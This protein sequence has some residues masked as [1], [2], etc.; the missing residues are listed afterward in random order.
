MQDARL[1]RR[2]SP[3]FNGVRLGDRRLELRVLKTVE[4]LARQPSA[5]ILAAARSTAEAEAMYRLLRNPR[6]SMPPILEPH[7]RLT[8]ERCAAVAKVLVIHDTSEFEYSGE[9]REG[10]GRLRTQSSQGFLFHGSL[11]VEAGT[12]Q[13]LG[14]VAIKTWVRGETPTSTITGRNGARKKSG[15][16]YARTEGKESDRWGQQIEASKKRL[17]HHNIVHVADREADIYSLLALLRE[18]GDGFVI[19]LA[20]DKKA[21]ESDDAERESLIEIA[22]RARASLQIDI[23]IAARTRSKM[24]RKAKTFTSRDARIA[25]VEMAAASAEIFG[26]RYA[27][28]PAPLPINVVH[29]RELDAPADQE[30]VEWILLTS[31]PIDTDAAIREVVEMYRGRWLIEEFFKVLKTGC[32][33]EKRELESLQTL[34]NVLALCIPI[35]YQLLAIRHLARSNPTAPARQILSTAQIAILQAKARLSADPSAHQAL[36]AVAYL[37]GHYLPFERKRPGWRVLARGMERLLDLEEG[38]LAR[39][40]EDPIKR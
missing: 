35:A 7:L 27:G 36:G 1:L 28:K 2:V 38:W 21:R 20:R 32:G 25:N 22:A 29:V 31:E 9:E 18:R 12:R 23:Q 24:P 30:P 39:A 3:E 19:R 11:A 26:P 34:T 37:G 4:A 15:S 17:G 33:M 40:A 5:S 6:V 8:A 14:L 13:P 16:D 10:L